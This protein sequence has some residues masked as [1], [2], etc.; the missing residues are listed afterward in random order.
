MSE[1]ASR[2][3]LPKGKDVRRGTELDD[4]VDL[5]EGTCAVVK[6]QKPPAGRGVGLHWLVF[7]QG[8]RHVRLYS[9]NQLPDWLVATMF[10]RKKAYFVAEI[11]NGEWLI[12]QI[13]EDQPW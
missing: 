6:V 12:T 13:I 7:A 3:P 10:E 1:G 5:P 4:P 11:Q 2:K 9:E 8:L